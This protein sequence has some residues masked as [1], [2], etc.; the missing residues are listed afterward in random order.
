LADQ[1]YEV[2]R[3][4]SKR[5][6]VGPSEAE[7]SRSRGSDNNGEIRLRI[8]NDAPVTLSLNGDME[9]RVLQLVPM[10]DGSNELVISGN[11]RSE[12]TYRSERGSV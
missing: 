12:N 8:G 9:G 10:D 2:A 4:R 3:T 11:N 7:S 5:N 6:S 1:S